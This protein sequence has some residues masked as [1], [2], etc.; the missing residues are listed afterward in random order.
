V[1]DLTE[2]LELALE[3]GTLRRREQLNRL[4]AGLSHHTPDRQTERL[5]Q[6][7]ATLSIQSERLIRNRIQEVKHAVGGLTAR[8]EV[9]S[10]LRT[11]SRGYAIAAADNGS[12]LTTVEQLT[13]GDRVNI[14]LFRGKAICSVEDLEGP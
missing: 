11:L 14:Q 3:N 8:L 5:Q 4:Q 10:P 1:D 6:Q 2:R 7:L 13:K 12:I 9:L